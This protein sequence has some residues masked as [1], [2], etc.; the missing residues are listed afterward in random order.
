MSTAG[1]GSW[2]GKGSRPGKVVRELDFIWTYIKANFQMAV[3]Y[4]VSFISQ[5]VGMFLNDG[6]WV[7]FW[8]LYFTKFPV[9][10]GWAREDV[11]LLWAVV[12]L[13]YG[14]ATGI[15][16][17]S[18]RLASLIAQGQLDYYLSLPKDPLLHIL[19]SRMS[20]NAWGDLLFGPAVFFAFVPLTPSKVVTYFAVSILAAVVLASFAVLVHSL[21][22]FI[23][24]AEHLAGELFMSMIHFSTYPISIFQGTVKVILFTLIPAAFISAIPVRLV[25]H[26]DFAVFLGLL[27]F[28]LGVA[29][30]ARWV[31]AV[32]LRRYE[33]G[34][35]M[36]LRS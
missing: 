21:A 5:V 26:F 12:T 25:R 4:R 7:V 15:F 8:W 34:N 9:V 10:K 36:I 30:L 23:G 24:N 31:F 29:A 32:G 11:L 2:L 22:F 17:N 14:L 35:L 18:N 16:G 13:A 1:K 33:S 6:L 3:E 28:A 27:G 19:I 20:V